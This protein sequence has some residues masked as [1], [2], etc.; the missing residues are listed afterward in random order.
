M[1]GG[2]GS[3]VS[4]V[5]VVAVV[6]VVGGV[7][8]VTL[9]EVFV[10]VVVVVVDVVVPVDVADDGNNLLNVLVEN[11]TLVLGRLVVCCATQ[12]SKNTI[13]INKLKTHVQREYRTEL[14]ILG[15]VKPAQPARKSNV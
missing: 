3:V 4:G 12:V 8:V 2:P 9:V 10:S 13:K 11:L 15:G 14:A 5:S 6:V 7:G 1:A